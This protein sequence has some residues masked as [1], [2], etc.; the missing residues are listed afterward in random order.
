MSILIILVLSLFGAGCG[1]GAGNLRVSGEA[2]KDYLVFGISQE[3]KYLTAGRSNGQIPNILQNQMYNNL[4]SLDKEGNCRPELAESWSVSEDGLTYT[5]HLR[6]DVRF[7]NGEPMTAE[8]VAFSLDYHAGKLADYP[9]GTQA[10]SFLTYYDSAEILDDYTVAVHYTDVYGP[11]LPCLADVIVGILPKKAFL[12][13]GQDLFEAS[14]IGT[15]PYRFVESKPGTSMELLANEVYFDG[16]PAIPHLI[17]SVCSDMDAAVIALESGELDF[18][19]GPSVSYREI[20][21]G[22]PWLTWYCAD[23]PGQAWIVFNTG[24]GTDRGGSRFFSDLR[25]RQAVAFAVDQ[26]ELTQMAT[27]GSGKPVTSLIPEGFAGYSPMPDYY[28]KDADQARSL[29]AEAGYP[30]GFSVKVRTI[31]TSTYYKL[32]EVLTGQL[33]EIGID[34]SLEVL[35]AGAYWASLM[36]D[37]DYDIAIGNYTATTPDA[38]IPLMQHYATGAYLNYSNHSIMELDQVLTEARGELEEEKRVKLYRRAM[39]LI[40][41]ENCLVVPVCS[42]AVTGAG[43]SRLKH[44]EAAPYSDWKVYQWTW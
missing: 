10:K 33:R 34:A 5:F 37:Y 14:P 11:T 15:G 35:E 16:V 9:G 17:F 27:D 26:E 42:F 19:A 43:D 18:L 36:S 23:S 38:D 6:K 29:L 24:L 1:S 40:L 39:E 3:P 20:V 22:S 12:E 41:K 31:T 2:G 25:V 44:V 32:A 13:M 7:H 21:E 30:D 4:I 28:P 8:D